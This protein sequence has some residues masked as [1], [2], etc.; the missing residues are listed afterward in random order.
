MD[1]TD[2]PDWWKWDV[3]D[4]GLE[5]MLIVLAHIINVYFAISGIKGNSESKFGH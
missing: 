5:R 2:Q 4:L 1:M 3:S